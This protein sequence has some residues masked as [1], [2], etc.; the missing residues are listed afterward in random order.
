[1]GFGE[2][3]ITAASLLQRFGLSALDLDVR[4]VRSERTTTDLDSPWAANRSFRREF[5]E[6]FGFGRTGFGFGEDP[7]SSR[8]DH[9]WSVGV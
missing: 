4:W 7:C 3:Q 6:A 9:E 2:L 1:M 5:V 8:E